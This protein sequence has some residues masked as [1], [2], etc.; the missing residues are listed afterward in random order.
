MGPGPWA[1]GPMASCSILL[2]LK[3]R[4]PSAAGPL[5]LDSLLRDL[6][7]AGSL[8]LLTVGLLACRLAS[9]PGIRCLAAQCLLIR[10][11]DRWAAGCG[12][13]GLLNGWS[14]DSDLDAFGPLWVSQ[15]LSEV[16]CWHPRVPF[17]QLLESFGTLWNLFGSHFRSFW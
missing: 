15:S 17:S 8:T 7:L 16:P 14:T 10:L 5:P 12:A 6:L 3:G 9:L 1:H 4:R 2:Y 13:A 11:L